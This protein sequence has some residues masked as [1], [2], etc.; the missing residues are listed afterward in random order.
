MSEAEGS[1]SLFENQIFMD[2]S[3]ASDP[4]GKSIPPQGHHAIIFEG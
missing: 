2:K 3:A 1:G 4:A